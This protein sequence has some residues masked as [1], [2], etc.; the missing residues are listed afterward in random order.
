M[1]KEYLILIVVIVAL[2]SYLTLKKE[3]QT[4]YTLPTPPAVDTKK[5]NRLV[6]EKHTD[7]T[8][9]TR[10][11]D[12]WVVT[13][14]A[15]PA[16]SFSVNRMLD[17]LKEL[18]LSALV[19]EKQDLVRYELDE[20]H[21][22]TVSAYENETHVLS[23]RIGKT[24]PT[25]NHTFVMLGN[26]PNIYHAKDSFRSHF[27][28]PLNEFRDRRVLS[29]MTED[30]TGI[31]IGAQDRQVRLTAHDTGMETQEE[32]KIIFKYE[33]G[34][35]PDPK[36][37]SNLLSTLSALTCDRFMEDSDRPALEKKSPRLKIELHSS[38]PILFHLYEPDE[39]ELPMIATSSMNAYVF[40][41]KSYVVEDITS[42]AHELVGLKE[43]EE[44]EAEEENDA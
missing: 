27:D 24:A 23:L 34:S 8:E 16:D 6:I 21:R 44:E 40:S 3:D 7:T 2:G 31:T 33:D 9:F 22:L 13:G 20:T 12:S 14:N 28:K 42:Y 25:F 30:I 17:V 37:V 32:S 1:K 19:S 18:T 15:Y 4:H 39:K 26:D 38:S 35:S 43:K 36:T 29:F 11:D 41:L 5:I 10:T